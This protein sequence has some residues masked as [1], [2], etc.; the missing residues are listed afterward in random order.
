MSAVE[1]HFAVDEVVIRRR[2]NETGIG[3]HNAGKNGVIVIMIPIT[4]S[5]WTK[6]DIV[7]NM[8]RTVNDKR[9]PQTASILSGIM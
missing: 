2:S 6:I 1:V 9:T 5:Y 7:G 4:E 8:L 3:A